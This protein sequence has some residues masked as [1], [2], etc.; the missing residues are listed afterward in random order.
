LAARAFLFVPIPASHQALPGGDGT[1]T[2]MDQHAKT[3]LLL[4]Y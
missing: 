4:K 3:Q 2:E 1:M